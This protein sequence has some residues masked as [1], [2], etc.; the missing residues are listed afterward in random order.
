MGANI[1]GNDDKKTLEFSQKVDTQAKIILNL[2]EKGKDFE[3]TLDLL[4]EKIDL[5][6]HNQ[7]K[8]TKHVVSDI[9]SI[10]E[11]IMNLKHDVSQIK[12]FNIK[13]TKQLKLMSS[14]DEVKR[15]EKYIDLWNPM[16]FVTREELTDKDLG[17]F[18]DNQKSNVSF[19]DLKKLKKEIK[20]EIKEEIEKII[21]GFLKNS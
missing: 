6:D 4:N 16:D 11:D 9:K 17:L 12:S 1:F 20:K 3:N 18:L 13:L 5:L 8:N 19:D 15:L 14:K 2:V 10:K 21:G 7:I